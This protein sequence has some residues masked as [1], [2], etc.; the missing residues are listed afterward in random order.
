MHSKM[1]LEQLIYA[2]AYKLTIDNGRRDKAHAYNSTQN[3]KYTFDLV[4]Y[5]LDNSILQIKDYCN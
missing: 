1:R 2:F 4:V 3:S 5:G